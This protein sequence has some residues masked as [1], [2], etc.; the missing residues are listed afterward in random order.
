MV[1]RGATEEYFKNSV[2][3]QDKDIYDKLIETRKEI[4]EYDAS[5]SDKMKSG[6]LQALFRY[7]RTGPFS[8]FTLILESDTATY[9]SNQLP[10]DLSM[11]TEGRVNRQLAFAFP[12]GSHTLEAELNQK[13]LTLQETGVLKELTDHWFSS[14]CSDSGDSLIDMT[15]APSKAYAVGLAD[16]SGAI[17]VLVVGIV[18][19]GIITAIEFCIYRWA[20][21][22]SLFFLFVDFTCIIYL[23]KLIQGLQ[24][25][26]VFFP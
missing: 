23:V 6:G 9:F 7:L 10:C 14:E 15:N 25:V 20:E 2:N 3:D 26:L 12:I 8:D 1:Y 16:I 11:I 22:V 18:L 24:L 17:L 19:G 5:E 13:L 4:A 21:S